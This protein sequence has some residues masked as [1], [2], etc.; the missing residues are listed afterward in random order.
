MA[1]MMRSFLQKI[2][3]RRELKSCYVYD[4]SCVCVLKMTSELMWFQL[5]LFEYTLFAK[6]V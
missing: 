2:S 6:G 4:K 1:R 5:G 3:K